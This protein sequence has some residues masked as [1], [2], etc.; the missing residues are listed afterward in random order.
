M[1]RL[2]RRR[3]AGPPATPPPGNQTLAWNSQGSS[4]AWTS[5][6]RR[7]GGVVRLR[8]RREPVPP[9]RRPSG[10]T[11]YLPGE[12]LTINALRPVAASGS[13]P[14][15]AA[16]PP[17]APA[18]A[19][20]TGSRS[21]PTSTAPTPSTSTT[22]PRTRP[23]GS[24]TRSA[25]PAAR[26]PPP[27]RSPATAASSTTPSSPAPALTNIGARWYDPVHR[28]VHQ[29]G[30]GAGD[31]QPAA[32]ERLHLR[33]RQPG[34]RLDP[35]GLSVPGRSICI[36][37]VNC[38]GPG[39]PPLPGWTSPGTGNGTSTGAGTSAGSSTNPV[40]VSPHVYVAANDPQLAQL[41]AAY[42]MGIRSTR[43]AS[44]EPR[45]NSMSG[46]GLAPSA[47]TA[48]HARRPVRRTVQWDGPKLQSRRRVQRG[49]RNRD[50]AWRFDRRVP[51]AWGGLK[52]G[53]ALRCGH[54]QESEGSVGLG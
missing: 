22:P 18:P 20:P 8:R 21:P 25:T 39:D 11:V 15:P 49:R 40:L 6:A 27:A 44:A 3:R 36:G 17:S 54:L 50:R 29:P 14:C 35:T 13:T 47:Q 19:P 41:G 38:N 51:R 32:A 31:G 33:R 48:A 30:P 45:T 9:D 53:P 42:Q 26:L 28:H 52:P 1:L 7:H 4:P 16:S 43:P 5:P 37:N 46:C 10:T 12:Q 34:Q 2:Q 24:S 23:G